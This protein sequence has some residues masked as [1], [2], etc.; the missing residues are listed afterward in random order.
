M[1]SL[2]FPDV[3]GIG[4]GITGA[5]GALAEA[6]K[7]RTERQNLQ[8]ILNPQGQ[9]GIPGSDNVPGQFGRGGQTPRYNVQQLAEIA[10]T[11][12][13]LAKMLQTQQGL[14][15]QQFRFTAEQAGKRSRKV[16]ERTDELAENLEK[17]RADISLMESA[18]TEGNLGFFS[19]DNLADITGVEGLRTAEGAQFRS[20]AKNFFVE[21]LSKVK[22]RPN[23]FIEGQILKGLAQIG[24]SEEANLTVLEA[25]KFRH[26]LD[27]MRVET[28]Q[29]LS[30]QFERQL[31]YVPGN[32]SGIVRET[33]KPMYTEREKQLEQNLR[34]I[35]QPKTSDRSSMA[36]LKGQ[37]QPGEILMKGP[38]G[39]FEAVPRDKVKEA[40]SK[41]WSL[42]R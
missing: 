32:L 22:G 13:T 1:G 7:T 12:P 5:S 4:Q 30:D 29:S 37:L 17:Q 10:R 34:Q 3:S 25:Q 14:E 35:I 18:I 28:T 24:R 26:D 31:G 2:I 36:N 19:Q 40:K 21:E 27:R 11:N 42:V 6:L 20:S 16:L 33:L 8:N 23:Q 39:Q 41:N 9:F 38:E 15:Q